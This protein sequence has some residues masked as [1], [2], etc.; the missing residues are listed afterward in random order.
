M[1]QFNS[2]AGNFVEAQINYGKPPPDGEAPY[3]YISTPPD[4]KPRTNF[5][6]EV[7]TLPVT[8]IRTQEPFT[9]TRNGFQ[10]E[11]FDSPGEVSWDDEE[12][13]CVT[14]LAS[15]SQPVAPDAGCALLCFALT[16]LASQSKGTATQTGSSTTQSGVQIK[17]TYYRDVE[18]LLKRVTG[19]SRTFIFDHTLR[20]GTI[21]DSR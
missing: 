19:A 1:V 3:N 21:K 20:K 14:L 18:K 15:A 9:L 10:L 16:S 7:V 4:G 12:Q 5:G 13:V 11:R 6:S 8:D 2:Q 17:T